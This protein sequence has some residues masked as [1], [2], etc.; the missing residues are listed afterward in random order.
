MIAT[1][2][3][4]NKLFLFFLLPAPA[5][6]GRTIVHLCVT[7]WGVLQVEQL[8]TLLEKKSGKQIPDLSEQLGFY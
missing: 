3:Q 5:C 6:A 8:F 2:Q 1:C 7:C 4:L